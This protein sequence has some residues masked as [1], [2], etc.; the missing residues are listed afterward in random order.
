LAFQTENTMNTTA[1]QLKRLKKDELLKIAMDTTTKLTEAE[2]LLL[3]AAVVGGAVGFL[4][5]LGF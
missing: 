4:V 3:L 1:T 2:Q 5:G